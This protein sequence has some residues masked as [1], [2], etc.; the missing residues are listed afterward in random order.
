MDRH[1]QYI[2]MVGWFQ[3]EKGNGKTIY[4]VQRP[5]MSLELGKG[6][7]ENMKQPECLGL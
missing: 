3:H 1:T 4:M 7:D 5:A 2:Q 6:E